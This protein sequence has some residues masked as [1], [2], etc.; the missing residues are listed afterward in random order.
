MFI[1]LVWFPNGQPV[2]HRIFRRHDAE[3]RREGRRRDRL[4]GLFRTTVGPRSFI[5]ILMCT[6]VPLCEVVSNEH[7]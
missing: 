1:Q 5:T 2:A 7:A 6:V 4:V 3:P